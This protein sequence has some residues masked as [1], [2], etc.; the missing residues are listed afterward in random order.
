MAGVEGHARCRVLLRRLLVGHQLSGHAHFRLAIRF[1]TSPASAG[2]FLQESAVVELRQISVAVVAE[3]RHHGRALAKLPRHLHR[4]GDVDARRATKAHSFIF[5]EVEQHAQRVCVVDPPGV[6]DHYILKVRRDPRLAN[7]L[8]DRRAFRLQF[9]ALEVRKERSA[10]RIGEADL[11]LLAAFLQRQ[12]NAA[13][14]CRLSRQ[15]R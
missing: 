8:S 5:R 4:T 12:R 1:H 10:A 13:L 3:H 9:S 7:A 15:S 14:A 11:N 2:L 6:I